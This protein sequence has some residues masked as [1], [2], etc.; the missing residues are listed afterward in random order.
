MTLWSAA[1]RLFYLS[2]DKF[3]VNTPLQVK[4]GIKLVKANWRAN[5]SKCKLYLECL[6]VKMQIWS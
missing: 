4:F 2:Y 5:K 1:K 3:I 6:L